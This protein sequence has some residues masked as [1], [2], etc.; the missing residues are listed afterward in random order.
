MRLPTWT[1]ESTVFDPTPAFPKALRNVHDPVALRKTAMQP[2]KALQ[3]PL[4]D[5]AGATAGTRAR[6]ARSLLM[7]GD[8]MMVAAGKVV[9]Q[10]T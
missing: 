3:R 4:H 5:T 7:L 8:V 9:L 10:S 6:M 1:I 2:E